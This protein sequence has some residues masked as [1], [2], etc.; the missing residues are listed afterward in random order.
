[1]AILIDSADLPASLKIT[2][3]ISQSKAFLRVPPCVATCELP[4]AW[5][6]GTSVALHRARAGKLSG[7]SS[8]PASGDGYQVIISTHN[9]DRRSLP[10]PRAGLFFTAELSATGSHNPERRAQHRYRE[11]V[12]FLRPSCRP[13]I[14]WSKSAAKLSSTSC[15]GL[16]RC[17]RPGSAPQL[18]NIVGHRSL[19]L[20]PAPPPI[21][22]CALQD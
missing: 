8:A 20:S 12:S 22:W 2:L 11:L 1:M 17:G 9:P 14:A 4:G 5:W 16:A 18:L 19:N 3:H 6:P 15:P 21:F 7:R 13:P 10:P